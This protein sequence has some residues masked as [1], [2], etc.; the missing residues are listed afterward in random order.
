M[1]AFKQPARPRKY[2]VY[3][4][5]LL[6]LIA[7][8]TLLYNSGSSLCPSL[9]L[10]LESPVG[11]NA[12]C[13][14]NIVY[15]GPVG[16]PALRFRHEIGK[17]LTARGLTD[18]A[19]VG[20]QMGHNAKSILDNWKT[21]QS[22]AL[23]DVWAQQENYKDPANRGNNHQQAMFEQT[24]TRLEQYKDITTYYRMLSTE[25]AKQI[26]DNSL[27][28]IY[29]D[30]RHDYCGVKE[31]LEA[32]W[33]KMRPGAI[34]AGHDFLDHNEVKEASPEQDWT[35]CQD[36]SVHLGAVRGAVEEFAEQHG[37]A[38]SATYRDGT[39]LSWLTQK[40]TRIEC[41]QDVGGWKPPQ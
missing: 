5:L 14:P 40:P 2:A 30:A 28:F 10:S 34:I 24:Q 41:V 37:L 39:W 25:A 33:P 36:G 15:R 1:P 18:G 38:L 9:L 20:V 27:D 19:E 35:I 29:I 21:C 32:Y 23:I 22:F 17:L 12:P 4:L 13:D 3:V 11:P 31:D 6:L 8:A 7:V 16:T 26:P